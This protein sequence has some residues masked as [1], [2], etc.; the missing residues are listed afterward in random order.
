MDANLY[1][2]SIMY[3]AAWTNFSWLIK[4]NEA[5]Y[6]E[7]FMPIYQILTSMLIWDYEFVCS[8]EGRGKNG[9]AKKGVTKLGTGD[10]S[11]LVRGPLLATHAVSQRFSRNDK[12]RCVPSKYVCII[13]YML[14]TFVHGF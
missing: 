4:I 1:N 8:L 2:M 10:V 9:K 12:I 14:C 6:Q 13:T 5:I 11:F 3:F 7:A